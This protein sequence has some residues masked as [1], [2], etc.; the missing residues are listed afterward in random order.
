MLN[1]EKAFSWQGFFVVDK[2]LEISNLDLIR[3]MVSIIE[4]KEIYSNIK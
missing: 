1:K 3:D 2:E 4:L